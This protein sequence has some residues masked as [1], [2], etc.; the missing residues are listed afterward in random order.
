M[1][2]L[3]QICERKEEIP[4]SSKETICLDLKQV[5][6]F[7]ADHGLLSVSWKI[8][9]SF[10]WFD[11]IAKCGCHPN[12][13]HPFVV[14]FRRVCSFVA[15]LGKILFTTPSRWF[16][17][18]GSISIPGAVHCI[19]FQV[20]RSTN[21]QPSNQMKSQRPMFDQHWYYS[22]PHF[23]R[24]I[25]I[26]LWYAICKLSRKKE[27][28][29]R[30]W[31][32]AWCGQRNGSIQATDQEE[33]STRRREWWTLYRIRTYDSVSEGIRRHDQDKDMPTQRKGA[34]VPLL[35]K[36]R[37]WEEI[38]WWGKVAQSLNFNSQNNKRVHKRCWNH[39]SVSW[40]C[41]EPVGLETGHSLVSIAWW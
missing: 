3:R 8:L 10:A 35:E 30:A 5:Y 6:D 33:A 11:N 15:R 36:S 28:I 18:S 25:L 26:F 19:A 22:H 27:T 17:V 4:I 40:Q 23:D 12:S 29:T 31:G 39:P 14:S 32:M 1:K 21:T 41:F 38:T 34:I 2:L 24:D 13:F 37:K 20:F 16:C 7:R 9:R